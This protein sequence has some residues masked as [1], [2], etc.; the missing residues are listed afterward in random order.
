ME[1]IYINSINK[2]ISLEEF[3][4][5]TYQIGHVYKINSHNFQKC[6]GYNKDGGPLIESFI[7]LNNINGGN[8]QL[9]FHPEGLPIPSLDFVNDFLKGKITEVDPKK[10]DELVNKFRNTGNEFEKLSLEL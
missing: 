2:R 9:I 4:K 1:D 7:I 6:I 10:Y 3:K 5:Y 8:I